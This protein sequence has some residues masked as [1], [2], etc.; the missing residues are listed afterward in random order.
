MSIAFVMFAVFIFGMLYTAYKDATTM[1]IPNWVSLMI[2]LAFFAVTPFVWQGWEVFGVH[3]LVGCSVFLF[4]FAVFAF[5][6]LGGGDAK[7][8]AATAF[9]WQ[10][11][12]LLQ[13]VILTTLAGGFIAIFILSGRK[14]VPASVL[15]SDWLHK[16]IKDET[17]MPYGLALSFGGIV[18]LLNSQIFE[19][20]AKSGLLF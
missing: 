7:L 6:W 20:A 18:T 2:L 5:G 1:T 16:L 4:G 9:W 8:M 3:L 10:W 12:D 15:Y 11:T 14:F 17:R 19:A 13:Y